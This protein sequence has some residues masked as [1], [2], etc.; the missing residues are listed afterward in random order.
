MKRFIIFFAFLAMA[1]LSVN[2]AER[3]LVGR[4][5]SASRQLDVDEY[6]YKKMIKYYTPYEVAVANRNPIPFVVTSDTG[7][8]FVMSDGTVVNSK[9][10]RMIYRKTKRFDI[11]KYTSF[12]WPRSTIDNVRVSRDL[13]SEKPLPLRFEPNKI[14]NIR[15]LVPQ[16]IKPE[17]VNITNVTF[18]MKNMCDVNIPLES[19]EE[20]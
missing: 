5:E 3:P 8:E 2:A 19:V 20:L 17:S 11:S 16:E 6:A 7:L 4:V 12:V 14:Y 9:S 15:I 10:R 18:D 1:S 13:M